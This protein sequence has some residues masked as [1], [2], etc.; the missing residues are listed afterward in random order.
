MYQF[1]ADLV[2]FFH[3]FITAFIILGL[4][5][6]VIGGIN[7]WRWVRNPWFRYTHLLGICIIVLQAWLGR[8]C[9]LTII[10]NSLRDKAGESTYPGSFVAYWVHDLLYVDLPFWMLTVFYTLFTVVVFICWFK[11]KPTAFPK[12][13]DGS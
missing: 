10:E 3:F 8:L 2:L 1:L 11:I 5:L 12:T 9:P 13:I 6:I 4:L 7:E